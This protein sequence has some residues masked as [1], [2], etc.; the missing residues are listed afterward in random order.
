MTGIFDNIELLYGL[1]TS[2]TTNTSYINFYS[3]AADMPL[4]VIIANYADIHDKVDTWASSI[5]MIDYKDDIT[6]EN[7]EANEMILSEK[8]YIKGIDMIAGADIHANSATLLEIKVVPLYILIAVIMIFALISVLVSGS[9]AVNYEKRN[10]GIFFIS[11]NN[12][13][14]T[15]YI[16]AIHHGIEIVTSLVISVLIWV[17]I[18]HSPLKDVINVTFYKIN[19]LIMLLMAIFIE[20]CSILMPYIMLHKLQPIDTIRQE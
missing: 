13:K 11:G 7:M 2:I 16:A 12:W 5:Y 15:V 3:M 8:G 1:R 9:I 17:V 6:Q 19:V 4:P 18:Q 14:N 10:Y 20:L